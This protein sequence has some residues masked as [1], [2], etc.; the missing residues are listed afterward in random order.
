MMTIP[1]PWLESRSDG[2]HNESR[3]DPS[4]LDF[5]EPVHPDFLVVRSEDWAA[6]VTEPFD[7][8]PPFFD[9]HD[10]ADFVG[11]AWQWS[12]SAWTALLAP[13]LATIPQRTTRET[14]PFTFG[15]LSGAPSAL[16][17]FL[18]IGDRRWLSN[19]IIVGVYADVFGT[20]CLF[21]AHELLAVIR[22]AG[23]AWP[24]WSRTNSLEAGWKA[25]YIEMVNLLSGDG[26]R[27]R[28]G[29]FLRG[30]APRLESDAVIIAESAPEA[31]SA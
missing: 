21:E 8:T 24:G 14:E 9:T 10:P 29:R 31:V 25:G 23:D 3:W 20:E 22:D 6:R 27:V 13:Q 19:S 2:S 17:A 28:L 4:A 5:V 16:V 18:G 12:R 30:E 11:S 26:S 7:R 15:Y 1:A